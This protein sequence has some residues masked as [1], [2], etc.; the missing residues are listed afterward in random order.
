M[1]SK[2]IQGQIS[3]EINRA[4]AHLKGSVMDE[5][6]MQNQNNNEGGGQTQHPPGAGSG[7]SPSMLA[8]L[9]SKVS[10]TDVNEM[11]REKANK[12]DAEMALR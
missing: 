7:M 6:D 10:I 9:E 1:I 11:L 8:Q 5:D 2:S 4:T 12:I 3:K